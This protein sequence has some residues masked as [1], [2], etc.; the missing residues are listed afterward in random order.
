MRRLVSLISASRIYTN[1]KVTN[2]TILIRFI[3]NEKTVST[4]LP[5]GTVLLDFIRYHQHLM[6]TKIGCRE[7][8]CGACTVLVGEMRNSELQYQ[9]MTCCLMPIG[10]AHGKHIVT[11]EGINPVP[12]TGQV[13]NGLN[14]IQQAMADEGATQCGFCTP[15]FVMSLAGFCLS[16]KKATQENAIAAIDG[17]ICRCTGYKSI[18]RAAA[19]VVEIMK[20]RNGED[21]ALFVA[22]K[23]I[24]PEYFAAIKNKLQS[25]ENGQLPTH[26][27]PLSTHLVGGGTDLYVQ[28]HDEM[29]NAAIRFLFDHPEL[30]GITQEGN[31]CIMGP[32]ATASDLQASLVINKA[33]PAFHRYA[34][35]V[36]STPIRNMAT[37]AGNFINASPI[38]DFTIFFLALDAQLDLTPNPSPGERGF[39]TLPLRKLYKGYK[40]L[41]KKPEEIIN[42]IWFELPGKNTLFNFEK[43]SKRTYLDIASV[44]SAISITIKGDVIESGCI[45]AG[46][47]GP[48]PIYLQKASEFLKGK[49][50]SESLIGEVIEIAQ[51]EISPISD[52]RGTA[53]YKRL[54]LRQ[55]IK[56]HF[57]TLFPE[58]A[59]EKLLI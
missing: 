44:N 41:D 46:G 12:G 37:I 13:M 52:T 5:P 42:K 28:K 19:K 58:M 36:S 11:I 9:S 2:K 1:F 30:N 22:K 39:R 55:L 6:G 10:N 32:S 4:D 15:G 38:G 34:K 33:F 53:E 3:I 16:D 25:L 31:K 57:I 56:A 54:L 20:E 59:T 35:L 23:K 26:H 29:T 43:V 40:L 18:E 45:S 14:P 47:V 17:N 7:G 50:I 51:T 24:L 8:D 48:V 49:N 21:P 27:S